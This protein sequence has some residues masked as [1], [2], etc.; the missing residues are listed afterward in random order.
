M[1]TPAPHPELPGP[2]RTH[3]P[4]LE[5]TAGGLAHLCGNLPEVREAL[6]ATGDTAA[7]QRLLDAVRG[8]GGAG[9]GLAGLVDAVHEAVQVAGDPWG[10]YGYASGLRGIHPAG[11]EGLEYVHRCPLELCAGR[12]EEDVRET[13]ARCSLS[14]RPLSREPLD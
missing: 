8:A 12:A 9:D 4:D 1:N 10:L 6:E 11:V 5:Q 7:L 14:G 3:R 2:D 13:P